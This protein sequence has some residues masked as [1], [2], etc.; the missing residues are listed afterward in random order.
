[1]YIYRI[2]TKKEFENEFGIND[3]WRNVK[4][5]F[6]HRMDYLLGKKLNIPRDY[7]DFEGN[8]IKDIHVIKGTFI[9]SDNPNIE[10]WAISDKM[11]KK[12]PFPNYKPR[13][14]IY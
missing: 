11:I 3:R 12:I 5:F 4:H 9:I 10:R 14:I 1:M 8:I 7:L 2:K 6:N 13:K